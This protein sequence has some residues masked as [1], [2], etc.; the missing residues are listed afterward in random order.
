[1]LIFASTIQTENRK[2]NHNYFLVSPQREQEQQKPNHKSFRHYT[3]RKTKK[4][5]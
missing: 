2:T 5:T 3:K 4:K 1:M